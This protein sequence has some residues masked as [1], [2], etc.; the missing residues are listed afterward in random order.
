M[1]LSPVVGGG[2]GGKVMGYVSKLF[3][4]DSSVSKR[5]MVK[6]ITLVKFR[7]RD[8]LSARKKVNQTP[9]TVIISVVIRFKRKKV[10]TPM[11]THAPTSLRKAH[12][13]VFS[14]ARLTREVAAGTS[15]KVSLKEFMVV[16][17]QMVLGRSPFDFYV[18]AEEERNLMKTLVGEKTSLGKAGLEMVRMLKRVIST[19]SSDI[20]AI[21]DE[22]FHLH[23]TLT[24]QMVFNV[25]IF[26]DFLYA[27]HLS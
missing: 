13:M 6:V 21:F 16:F 14:L 10:F 11:T 2:K 7:G 8:F 15:T 5:I 22:R 26:L 4:P 25:R 24:S 20:F 3:A 19:I 12:T 17:A 18:L 23:L 9:S 27:I 1:S